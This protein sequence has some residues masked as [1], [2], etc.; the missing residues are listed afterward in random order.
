MT[1]RSHIKGH[2]SPKISNKQADG[3]NA[4]FDRTITK[5]NNINGKAQTLFVDRQSL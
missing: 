1:N 3:K 2:N 5:R 4:G